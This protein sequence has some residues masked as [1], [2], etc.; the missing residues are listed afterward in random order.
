M[1]LNSSGSVALI[2]VCGQIAAR[3]LGSAPLPPIQLPEISHN[4]SR[5]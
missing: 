2:R 3:G 1:L 4:Y 5:S